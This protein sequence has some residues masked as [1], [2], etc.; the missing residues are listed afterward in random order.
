MVV[1]VTKPAFLEIDSRR[2]CSSPANPLRA[3]SRVQMYRRV[4]ELFHYVVS[5]SSMISN[6]LQCCGRETCCGDSLPNRLSHQKRTEKYKKPMIRVLR[7]LHCSL[8]SLTVHISHLPLLVQLESYLANATRIRSPPT[9]KRIKTSVTTSAP[10]HLLAQQQI[11]PFHRVPT[12]EGI[13]IPTAPIP[14]Q[15]QQQPSPQQQHQQHQQ[16]QQQVQQVQQVQ[17]QQQHQQSQQQAPSR[18]RPQSPTAGSTMM[19]APAGSAGGVME[20]DPNALPAPVEP[21]PKKKGRT[22]TPWTAEEE[23]RLKTMRDAGRSWS[24]IAKVRPV[25]MID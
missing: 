11:H 1:G 10:P 17:Q 6:R 9:S 4:I 20:G 2:P 18:K 3:S 13:P 16:H 7:S 21:A 25:Q 19:A 22:N 24:E 23:Q 15:Q 5:L 12:F 14:H 8:P